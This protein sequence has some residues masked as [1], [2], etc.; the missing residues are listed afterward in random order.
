[1]PNW[2]KV[3]VSGSDASLIDV[4]IDDWGSVSASLS[5]IEAGGTSQT[6][7]QVTTNGATTTDDVTVNG[8]TVSTMAAGTDNSV[9]VRN[10]SGTLVTDEIDS[11]VWG[12]SLIDGSGAT[13]RVTYYSDAN[14]ITS[15]SNFTFVN[16]NLGI[17][18]SNPLYTAH[19]K[20]GSNAQIL[21]ET[22]APYDAGIDHVAGIKFKTEDTDGDDRI[23]GGIFFENTDA[24]DWGRGRLI[25]ANLNSAGNTNVDV[26]DWKLKVEQDG[27]VFIS[28]SLEVGSTTTEFSKLT[29]SGSISTFYSASIGGDLEVGAN[30]QTGL[31][32]TLFAT[33]RLTVTQGNSTN[34]LTGYDATAYPGAVVDYVVRNSS[35]DVQRT[36]TIMI[37]AANT[38][39]FEDIV[40]TETTTPDVGG[41]DTGFITFTTSITTAGIWTLTVNH[42]EASNF[43][44]YTVFASA[45]LIKDLD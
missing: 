26:G 6:L 24:A 3:I 2:K 4:T 15:D 36:G 20:S 5:S 21:I 11:R 34:V 42:T 28:K 17:G 19:F 43:G 38:N 39:I 1:M 45:R 8:I 14:T 32:S 35:K 7:Q 27:N 16:N 29:V 10:S 31:T 12:S 30:A 44:T 13:N 37:S 25:L 41:L 40:H 9:V 23:K 33:K 22:D 18:T